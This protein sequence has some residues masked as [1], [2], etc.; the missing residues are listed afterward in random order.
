MGVIDVVEMF[1][2]RV[3]TENSRMRWVSETRTLSLHAPIISPSALVL[4][5]FVAL[6]PRFARAST[7][8]HVDA[9]LHLCTLLPLV[10]GALAIREA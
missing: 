1:N 7:S 6:S 10:V 5:A 8:S 4:A 3:A 9:A 2:E